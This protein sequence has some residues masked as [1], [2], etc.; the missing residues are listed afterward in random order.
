MEWTYKII[1]RLAVFTSFEIFPLDQSFDS[2]LDSERVGG[3]P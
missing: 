2:L 1:I 3:E